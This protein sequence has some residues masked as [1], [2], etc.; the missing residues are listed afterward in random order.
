MP[1]SRKDFAKH[2]FDPIK[3]Y[4][5]IEAR[6]ERAL[7]ENAVNGQRGGILDAACQVSL[8]CNG[9]NQVGTS[10]DDYPARNGSSGGDRDV[11]AVFFRKPQKVFY[12]AFAAAFTVL[13]PV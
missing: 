8:A 4:L 10:L 7:V 6:S 13:R 5:R 3:G 9:Y 12:A 1:C 2:G 11:Y